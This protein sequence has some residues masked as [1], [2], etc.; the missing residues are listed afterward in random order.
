[1]YQRA[2]T[3]V[4][5]ISTN[6]SRGKNRGDEVLR[7][8]SNATGGQAFY[9]ISIE[10]VANGF[11]RIE[12]ELRSQYSLIYRPAAFKNDGSFRTINLQ[13]FDRRYKVRVHSG[14]FAS[15]STE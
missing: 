2:E 14:Y 6:I 11:Q 7:V 1:M 9:P 13:A 5:A 10:D 4:Y 12:E 15:R 8:I 3:I